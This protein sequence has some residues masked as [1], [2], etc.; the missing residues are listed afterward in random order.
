MKTEMAEMQRQVA[1]ATLSS[2]GSPQAQAEQREPAKTNERPASD[3]EAAA[4]AITDAW[5]SV[6]SAG[7]QQPTPAPAATGVADSAVAARLSGAVAHF[8]LRVPAELRE[9]RQRMH[10][11][12]APQECRRRERQL[13]QP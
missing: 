9:L 12:R 6:M 11:S 1:T 7:G 4:R 3:V 8:G 2:D 10:R 13:S 5:R